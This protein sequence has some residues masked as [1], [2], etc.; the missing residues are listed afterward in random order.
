M[1]E[2][3]VLEVCYYRAREVLRTATYCPQVS[4]LEEHLFDLALKVVDKSVAGMRAFRKS[5]D[6]Q[7]FRCGSREP[8]E[9]IT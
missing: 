7:P 1:E 6:L 3:R 8:N 2:W 9:R 4:R 5:G